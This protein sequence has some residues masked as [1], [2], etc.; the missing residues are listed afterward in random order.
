MGSTIIRSAL[1]RL[2]AIT[3]GIAA[4][5]AVFAGVARAGDELALR[6][7]P[8]EIMAQD[9]DPW[10]GFNER[11]FSFNHAVLDR[12]VVKPAAT[13]WDKVCPD[14]AK[15]GVGR[16]IDNLKMPRRLVNNLLQ[17]RV[18]DAGAEVG[19]GFSSTRRQASAASS[20]SRPGF[21]SVRGK[22]TWARPL[23]SGASVPARTSCCHSSLPS[24]CETGSGAPST[25]CSIRSGS[26]RS[27]AVRS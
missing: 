9:Y 15:R 25:P 12:F 23:A 20:T 17:G 5:L 24:P 13:A 14:V 7:P 2:V 26:C 19:D 4:V 18:V 27:S 8:D 1:R 22:P 21:T 10:A 16:A 11:M 6:S 3:F